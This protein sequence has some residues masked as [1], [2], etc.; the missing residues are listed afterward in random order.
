MER[1]AAVRGV[2]WRRR[3]V[4]RIGVANGGGVVCVDSGRGEKTA[5]VVVLCVLREEH[6]WRCGGEN[7]TTGANRE[8]SKATNHVERA[9]QNRAQSKPNVSGAKQNRPNALFL[10]CH[11][12]EVLGELGAGGV[13]QG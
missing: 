7:E 10:D 1:G 12:P 5:V 2:A 13:C 6:G 4:V 3:V 9:F 11:S 8:W